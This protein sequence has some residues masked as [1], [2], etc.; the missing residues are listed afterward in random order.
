MRGRPDVAEHVDLS[1]STSGEERDP[2]KGTT[3]ARTDVLR[4]AANASE[5]TATKVRSLHRRERMDASRRLLGVGSGGTFIRRAGLEFG[6][7]APPVASTHVRRRLRTR[8]PQGA[9]LRMPQTG[10]TAPHKGEVPSAAA[11]TSSATTTGRSRADAERIAAF[12]AG[13]IALAYR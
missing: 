1:V 13:R 7:A 8:I 9:D 6:V 4:H 10:S 11:V 5:P 3:V 12:A 2:S